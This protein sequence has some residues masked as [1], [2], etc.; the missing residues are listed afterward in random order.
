MPAVSGRT[1]DQEPVTTSPAGRRPGVGLLLGVLLA[2][3]VVPVA[4]TAVHAAWLLP[5]VV[6]LGTASL[7]RSGRSLLDR[8]ML[9]L[10]LLAGLTC[11]VG[12]LFTVWPW[13]LHPVPVT[14]LALTVLTVAAVLSRRAPRLPRPAGPTWSRSPPRR[15]PPATSPPP[16]CGPTASASDSTSPWSART[17]AAT[18]HCST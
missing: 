3:W 14:G 7:L 11:A 9:A 12:L 2:C 5:P 18:P 13:G 1:E 16:T 15:S 6:L 8:M 4:A 17:T 10:A